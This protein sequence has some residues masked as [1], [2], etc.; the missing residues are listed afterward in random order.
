MPR[1]VALELPVFKFNFIKK[2]VETLVGHLFSLAIHCLGKFDSI[3]NN[4]NTMK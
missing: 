3:V 4:L 2:C 1:H